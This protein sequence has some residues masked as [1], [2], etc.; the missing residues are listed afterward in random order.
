M[1]DE[2]YVIDV[3]VFCSML[4]LLTKTMI[5]F[6]FVLLISGYARRE[7]GRVRSGPSCPADARLHAGVLMLKSY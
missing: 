7:A 3:L 6:C 5:S 2:R 1:P 4:K